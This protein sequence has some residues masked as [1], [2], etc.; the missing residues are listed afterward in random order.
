MLEH[1]RLRKPKNVLQIWLII[2]KEKKTTEQQK[3][4]ESALLKR[5]LHLHLSLLHLLLLKLFNFSKYI[6]PRGEV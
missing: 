2:A 1:L 3:H 5:A 4:N 6:C